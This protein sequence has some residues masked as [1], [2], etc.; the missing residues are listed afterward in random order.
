MYFDYLSD[1]LSKPKIF[2]IN[3]KVNKK[4]LEVQMGYLRQM[5]GI[6]PLILK[7]KRGVSICLLELEGI[8]FLKIDFII[9][10]TK[11]AI[12]ENYVNNQYFIHES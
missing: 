4:Y 6:K 12:K 10:E 7:D 3:C 1:D 2:L 8:E 5:M 11:I 9:T